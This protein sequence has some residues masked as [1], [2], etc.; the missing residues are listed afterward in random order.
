MLYITYMRKTKLHK[1]II[2]IFEQSDRPISIPEILS[3]LEKVGVSANKTTVYRQIEGLLRERIVEEVL[4]DSGT[5]FY[6]LVSDHHHHF[7]CS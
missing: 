1:L 6:E 7:R 5:A 2:E 4:L 3:M